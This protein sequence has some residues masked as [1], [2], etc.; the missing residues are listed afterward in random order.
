MINAAAQARALAAQAVTAVQTGRS[1]GAV[2]DELFENL[3]APLARERSLIQ[4][5]CYGT[6]RWLFLLQA[7][8]PDF[9]KRPLKDKDR[10]LHALL[11]IGLYQ[12]LFMRVAAHAA[13]WE[14]V[15]AVKFLNKDWARALV[16]GVLRS[17]LRE[18]QA[19]RARLTGDRALMQSQPGW[20]LQ[21]LQTAYPGDWR[22]V[23]QA[24]N[25]RPP[26]ILRVNRTHGSRA[27]YHERLRA[28]GIA[29]EAPEDIDD[30]LRLESP[31]PVESL[32]GFADGDVS[33]QDAAAQ[34]AAPL[35]AAQSG[36][37]VLDACAA[38]GGK[39]AHLLELA[40]DL[41]LVVLDIDGKRL[42]RVSENFARLGLHGQILP[43][44]AG[45]PADWWDGR[46][47]QRIL[48]DA[49]CSATGVIRR[50]PDIRLHRRPEDLE[51]LTAQQ[52]RLLDALWPLLAP[53]GKL[54]Y[55]TC[56][57]LPE[58]NGQQAEAFCARHPDARPAPLR[59]TALDRYARCSTHG[60]QILPGC[61]GLDGFFYAA[62]VKTTE[63]H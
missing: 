17:V 48:L 31:L 10:D 26:M 1:L 53:G 30:A 33:V 35:L 36:D 5:L 60:C 42:A 41:D 54:L 51:R 25:A 62:L 23:V 49:P 24:S 7:L 40:P 56:S 12:L 4:E 22:A 55:V 3:P 43:G 15:E 37:R 9:L 39:A 44:D 32:P 46:P 8:L 21:R 19:L 45:R 38:P 52:T 50:H 57:I 61:G 16:N 11:L 34:L 29:A 27:A 18:E 13:V 58:E 59:H 63:G 2:L 14:T 6:L 47:F 28:A 20:L